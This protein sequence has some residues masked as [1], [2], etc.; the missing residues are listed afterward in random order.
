MIKN[1]ILLLVVTLVA[2]PTHSPGNSFS[3]CSSRLRQ[4]TLLPLLCNASSQLHPP[5]AALLQNGVGQE[6]WWCTSFPDKGRDP[7][8][9]LHGSPPYSSC[10]TTITSAAVYSCPK[11]CLGSRLQ[12]F[13]P[14]FKIVA[15]ADVENV[16]VLHLNILNSPFTRGTLFIQ[17]REHLFGSPSPQVVRWQGGFSYRTLIGHSLKVMQRLQRGLSL[18]NP[19]FFPAQ[20]ITL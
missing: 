15:K 2:T 17:V 18:S 16:P 7:A 5:Y 4:R 19:Y 11:C 10:S 13:D 8:F 14:F 20:D 6:G 9:D 3:S 1:N 12:I